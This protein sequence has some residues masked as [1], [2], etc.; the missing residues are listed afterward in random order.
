M[1]VADVLYCLLKIRGLLLH[2]LVGLPLTIKALAYFS[3]PSLS[4]VTSG[5]SPPWL[6]PH[7]H[8]RQLGLI[9]ESNL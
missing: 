6:D 8:T 9:R 7:H 1:V 5:T 3:S 4:M 2:F